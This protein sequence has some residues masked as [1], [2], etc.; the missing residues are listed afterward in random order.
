MYI[1]I[2]RWCCY[3]WL[4][5]ILS[6]V[7]RCA[8][9]TQS[10]EY[11]NVHSVEQ[12]FWNQCFIH[13]HSKYKKRTCK[14][15]KHLLSSFRLCICLA[16]RIYCTCEKCPWAIM[17]Q[18]NTNI[19]KIINHNLST[20]LQFILWPLLRIVTKHFLS[21]CLSNKADFIVTPNCRHLLLFW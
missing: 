16:E 8:Y 9:I 17:T 15:Y 13:C 19:F 3:C 10:L 7:V 14:Q 4:A 6:I 21:F 11:T 12:I 2:I 18:T 1:C 5:T 20:E